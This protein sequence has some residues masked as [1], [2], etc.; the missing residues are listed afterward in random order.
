MQPVPGIVDSDSALCYNNPKMNNLEVPRM[1]TYVTYTNEKDHL[2]VSRMT[3]VYMFLI[4]SLLAL[5]ALT[6]TWQ[7]Y[8]FLQ[9]I[10][11]VSCVFSFVTVTRTGHD[12]ELRFEGDRLFITDRRSGASYEVWDIPASDIVLKQSKKDASLD[13][14]VMVIKGTRFIFNYI[15]NFAELREYIRINYS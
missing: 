8:V 7:F 12:F 11:L 1:N 5:M 2:K 10:V 3:V 15:Y 9:V 13:R 14:G 4:M 6:V